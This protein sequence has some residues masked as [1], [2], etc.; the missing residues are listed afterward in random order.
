MLWGK[1]SY[2]LAPPGRSDQT[3]QSVLYANH[4]FLAGVCKPHAVRIR[5]MDS[6]S[7][8]GSSTAGNH[9]AVPVGDEWEKDF[10]GIW[11]KGLSSS[12]KQ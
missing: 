6:G 3:A 4:V 12:K 7:Q 1:L 10:C 8:Q 11:H 5:S 2:G 9:H